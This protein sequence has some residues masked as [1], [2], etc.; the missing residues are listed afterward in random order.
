MPG[1]LP[2]RFIGY[3]PVRFIACSC[4]ALSADA[5]AC[6]SAAHACAAPQELYGNA[7]A[8]RL[9]SVFSRL[10]T[11]YLQARPAPQMHARS[12]PQGHGSLHV[13]LSPHRGALPRNLF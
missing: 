2:V 9:I 7:I 11:H 5:Q 13:L 3:L 4:A 12:A 1:Y 10:F 6:A 8:G